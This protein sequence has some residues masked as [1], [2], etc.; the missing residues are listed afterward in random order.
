[1]GS[2]VAAQGEAI[3]RGARVAEHGVP[4]HFAHAIDKRWMNGMV[5]YPRPI[6][7]AEIIGRGLLQIG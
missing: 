5:R 3:R 7:L 2:R 4:V 1:M 6:G